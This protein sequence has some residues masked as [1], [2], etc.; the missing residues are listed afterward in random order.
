[1]RGVARSLSCLGLL[2]AG[3]ILGS[4]QF[5]RPSVLRAEPRSEPLPNAIR[6]RLR[7]T[8]RALSETMQ[9]LQDEKRY[10]P[11]IQ[12]LN[13]FAT[14]SGGVDAVAD[15]ESGQGVD[16][17]T[18]AGL[19]AGQALAELSEHLGRDAEGHVTY[20][21]KIVRIYSPTR[22]RQLFAARAEF[23]P[24][25]AASSKRPAAA[26]KESDAAAEKSKDE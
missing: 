5:G 13:A 16:P 8:D 17:E 2:F 4:L 11:A 10:V 18:F 26:K 15:L 14:S 23:A 7:E 24:A 9:L 1:M 22:L 21:N 20:K 12:G 6:D 25:A 19:Y 3:Y